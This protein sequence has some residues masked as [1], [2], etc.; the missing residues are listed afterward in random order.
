VIVV[1]KTISYPRR[2]RQS[3]GASTAGIPT[4]ASPSAAIEAAPEPSP[5]S[6]ARSP[7]RPA[8]PPLQTSPGER[9]RRPSRTEAGGSGTSPAGGTLFFGESNFLTLVPGDH[10][11]AESSSAGGQRQR[12]MFPVPETPQSHQSPTA[13]TRVSAATMRYLR[14]EGALTLPDLQTC[15]PALQ[16][17]FTWFHPCFPVVDRTD[18]IRRLSAMDV[19]HLLL[20]AMLFIG[21]TYCDDD[22]IRSMGFADRSEAKNLLYMRAR[23][24]FHAD[25]ESDGIT[26]IQSV[27]LMSFWRGGPSDIRDVRYWLGVVISFAESYGLHRS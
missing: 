19:S 24:L 4:A 2:N 5:P 15:V 17:Y 22:T 7:L 14:D 9:F 23:M 21:A 6:L 8:K 20:Q 27:F 1:D 16:A 25:W 26:V 3:Q 18:F 11:G 12:L 10:G 13:G